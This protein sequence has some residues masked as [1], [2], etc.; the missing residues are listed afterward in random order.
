MKKLIT[1]FALIPL[2]ATAQQ[3]CS[4][5]TA[6]EISEVNK[7]IVSSVKYLM[8]PKDTVNESSRTTFVFRNVNDDELQVI[9]NIS[10]GAAQLSY[11]VAP[12]AMIEKIL[13]GFYQVKLD[14]ELKQMNRSS[15]SINCT[16]KPYKLYLSKLEDDPGYWQLVSR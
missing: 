6:G 7:S 1:L 2:F 10:G 15:L 8:V 3:P 16:G 5:I 14:K 9:Y 4:K 13:T 12:E 11:V